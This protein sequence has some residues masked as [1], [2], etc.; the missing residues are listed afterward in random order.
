MTETRLTRRERRAI[1]AEWREVPFK[2]RRE[3]AR[4]AKRGERHPD[5]SVDAAAVR[6][7]RMALQ[8]P[9]SSFLYTRTFQVMLTMTL[10][11]I[12]VLWAE[13]FPR[14]TSG[15]GGSACLLLLI[16]DWDLKRDARRI[17]AVPRTDC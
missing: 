2:A 1:A 4:L 13:P 16:F 14:W 6:F 11:L 5:G 12:A 7:S 17:L 3:A 15:I 8:E 9:S 10:L